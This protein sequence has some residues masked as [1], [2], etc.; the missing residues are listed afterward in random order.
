M[1][2][3]C[4]DI[5]VI[6]C[7]QNRSESLKVTL[8]CLASSLCDGIQVEVIIVDN[9]GRDN[10]REVATSFKDRIPLRYVYEPRVGVYGKSHALNRALDSGCLGEII[11][12]LDDDMSPHPDWFKG[13]SAICMRWPEADIFAG[14]TYIIWPEGNVP[15]WARNT[16][17]QSWI[18]S[19]VGVG[20]LDSPLAKGR[21]F[22]GNH[23]WFRSRI[24]DRG[25]RF[26]DLWLTEPDFQLSMAELGYRGI[27]GPDALAGHRVQPEL[28]KKKAA[29][30][31]AKKVG[32]FYARLRLD[33]YRGRIKQARLFQ[34]HPMLAR[35]FCLFNH[36]RWGFMFLASYLY[37]SDDTRFVRRLIALERISAYQEYLGTAKR[38]KEYSIWKG[39]R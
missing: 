21:W 28:L 29:I 3:T 23:F 15:G 7:T 6:I 1:S 35:L 38:M 22:S 26:R 34:K 30:D 12:V 13:V 39:N 33:P 20:D 37:P 31:R 17:L 27:S 36:I 9:A 24:I 16:K 32:V 2:Q 25:H 19:A 10:T 8:E 5:S 4:P 18:F 14:K 11:A